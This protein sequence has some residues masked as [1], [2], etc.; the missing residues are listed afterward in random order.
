MIPPD[1]E[2]R[3]AV[4]LAHLRVED[5][6]ARA[7]IAHPRRKAGQHRV[8]G[9][10]VVAHQ[11]V[12]AGQAHLGGRVISLG[13]AQEGVDHQPGGGLKGNLGAKLVR[14]VD[15]VAGLEPHHCPPALRPRQRR[16]L[17]RR[18][19]K[20]AGNVELPVRADLGRSR[21]RILP[22]P[23]QPLNPGMR[24]VPRA[25]D[26]LGVEF[27]IDRKD[28]LDVQQARRGVP[29]LQDQA[30]RSA[31]ARLGGSVDREDDRNTPRLAGGEVHGAADRAGLGTV[32]E[33]LD[34][35][36]S[37]FGQQIQVAQLS[38]RRGKARH[39][40][41]NQRVQVRRSNRHLFHY[42]RLGSYIL[43]FLST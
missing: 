9:W 38:E 2:V 13:L 23:A 25:E 34:R 31:D 14:S 20:R 40:G 28:L 16:R 29:V 41:G 1:D 39:A 17:A 32:Q 42:T 10:V 37:A 4:V 18:D 12:V 21:D 22:C 35:L 19:R 6:L 5:R 33:P 3:Y 11:H 7:G 26:A 43:V 36:V 15:R 30:L 24:L 8:V 27:L